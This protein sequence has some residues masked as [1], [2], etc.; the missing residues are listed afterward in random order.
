M[1]LLLGSAFALTLP[2]AVA[3]A[4]E[5]DPNALVA[6]LIAQRTRSE[7]AET[8]FQLGVT[9]SLS[10]AHTWQAGAT[11]D[12]GTVSVSVPL[13]DPPAWF[14]AVEQAHQ[15]RAETRVSE[16]T[17]LDA[18]YAAAALVYQAIAADA[19][20]AVR[21]EGEAAATGTLG[22][23][24]SRVDAGLE[25]ELSARS[26]QVGLLQAEAAVA[27]AEAERAVAYARLSRALEAPVPSVEPAALPDLP[28]APGRSPWLEAQAARWMAAKWERGQ[29]LAEIFPTGGLSLSTNVLGARTGWRASLTGTWTFDGLAGPFLRFHQAGIDARIAE[30]QYEALQRDLDL[31]LTAATAQARAADRTAEFAQAQET[32]AAESLEIGQTRL[33]SGLA[34]ALEVLRLQDDLARARADRVAAELQRALTRLEARRVAG[35]GW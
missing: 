32:L 22:I 23:V 34:S 6:E 1:I 19:A 5:V 14:N 35:L 33:A 24:R 12:T 15:A 8:L 27:G 2:E 29:R 13:I 28:A 17:R 11:T 16:A 25:S 18:Q 30:I 26:A 31:G 4:A 3:R 7:S 20:L 10:V 21:K 9:P